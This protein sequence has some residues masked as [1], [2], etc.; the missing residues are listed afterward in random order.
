MMR[1]EQDW[2]V[3]ENNPIVNKTFISGRPG[4]WF[5]F[6][7]LLSIKDFEKNFEIV[8]IFPYRFFPENTEII[9]EI[10]VRNSY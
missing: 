4:Y 10:Y 7:W 2:N 9:N 8:Y 3:S 1:A 6:L 5:R